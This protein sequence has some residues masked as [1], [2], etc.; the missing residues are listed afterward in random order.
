MNVQGQTLSWQLQDGT[1]ELALHREPCNE[2]GSASLTEL[3][4]FASALDG[5]EKDAHALIVHSEMKPGFCAGADLRELHQRSQAMEKAQAAGGVR[6]FLERIHRV[7]NRV[8]ASPL[9]TIAAVHGVTFGGGFELALVCDL[10]IADKMARFCFP[11]LRLGLIPGFG[12]IP[13]LKRDLGNAV[14]RDLLLTGRSFNATKAQQIG[15]VSQVVAEGEALR[16]ARATAAQTGK[17]DRQ[18]AV[19]AKRFIKPIPHEELRREIDIFCELFSRPEVEA[20]LKK[21]VEST[22]AQPYLP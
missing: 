17:F 12:G 22:D 19:A 8:D 7:F 1:I 5:L 20:G 3:E 4:Q 10:I 15:L 9:T 13:R 6:D 16:A 14:V 11:E 2:I 21:F 18:T